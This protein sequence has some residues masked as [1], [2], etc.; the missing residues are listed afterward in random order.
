MNMTIML[1]D[2]SLLK[3]QAYI[4]GQWVNS[5]DGTTFAVC[6]PATEEH[7]TEVANVGTNETKRAINAAGLAMKQWRTLPAKSRS[8][9]LESW[10]QLLLENSEDLARLMTAEQG[11]PL[12]EARGEVGY[13]A[14]YLKWFAEEGKRVYGDLIPAN[15]DRR[16]IAI[17]QPIGVVAAITPWNFPNAMITRKVAPALAAGCAIVLKPAAETPLSALALAELAHRAGLPAGLFSVLPTSDAAAVGTEMTENP[18]VKKITF[19]GSTAVGKLLMKQCANTVKRTSMELG[20]NAPII[21]FDDADLDLAVAGAMAS[22]FRNSGQ[23]CICANRLLV[24]AGI[25]EAFI[26]KFTAAV[27]QLSLGNGLDDNTTQGPVIT[28]KAVNEIHAKV[29]SAVADGATLVTGG[30]ISELGEQFYAP[31]LLTN[32]TDKMR[33]FRE[34]I[35]GPVAAVMKF[36]TEQEAVA[37]ANDT[38]FGLAAYFYTE[39]MTRSWRV[40]E[41]LEYG[42]VGVNETAIGADII[43]FGGIKESGQGREGSKYGL[44]DYLEIKYIC[45]GGMQR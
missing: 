43:P 32:V 13:G 24:Q 29:L 20:G 35:F 37:L 31:T 36:D 6:N 1:K 42:M 3:T 18:I 44:D 12:F 8:D 26:E 25:Y 22:K 11:K 19:T 16:S 2:P 40:A 7:I 5:D 28:T 41:A 14:S 39:H 33:V 9:I 34:E 23:T 15:T 10:H 21:I 38:P 17:K 27:K 30:S 4:N 45:L